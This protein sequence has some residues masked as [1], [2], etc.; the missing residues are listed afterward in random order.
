M[1]AFEE[2]V[3]RY[4]EEKGYWARQCVKV[5]RISKE[6]KRNLKKPSMPTPEIDIVA[7]NVKKNELLLV[8]VKSLLGSYGVYYEAVTGKDPKDK[9]GYKFFWNSKFRG[10]VTARLEEEF[11][12]QG[13]INKRTKINYALAAGHIHSPEDESKIKD[14]FS[15]QKEKWILFPPKDITDTIKKLSEKGWEDNLVTMTAKLTKEDIS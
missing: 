12:E 10:I 5:N 8:E 3:K 15:R 1:N 4:L 6:D 14:Y 11:L 9:D 13:F 7:L 2:I